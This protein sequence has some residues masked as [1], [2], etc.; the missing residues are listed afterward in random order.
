VPKVIT[1]RDGERS[2]I[3]KWLAVLGVAVV[4][5]AVPS[6]SLATFDTVDVTLKQLTN[7]AGF[8]AFLTEPNSREAG[9]KLKRGCA[10][11]AEPILDLVIP[12]ATFADQGTV[13]FDQLVKGKKT[14]DDFFEFINIGGRANIFLVSD[15][16]GEMK[17]LPRLKPSPLNFS[18]GVDEAAF[19]SGLVLKGHFTNGHSYLA[20]LFS[21]PKSVAGTASDSVNIVDPVP[22]PASLALFG[23]GLVGLALILRRKLSPTSK[24]SRN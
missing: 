13:R 19:P 7:P 11:D 5:L 16:A 20:T 15:Q 8:T 21:N 14:F 18:F 3:G 4:A 1:N 24:L 23:S 6:V 2:G 10:P 17:L 22:E 12:D 9:C